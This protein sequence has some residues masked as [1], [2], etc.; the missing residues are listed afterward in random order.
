MRIDPECNTS[1]PL[2]LIRTNSGTNGVGE[3]HSRLTDLLTSVKI[4]LKSVY[5]KNLSNWPRADGNDKTKNGALWMSH[6]HFNAC[7]IL[8]LVKN[9]REAIFEMSRK[10]TLLF[11]LDIHCT[12]KHRTFL[13]FRNSYKY[14]FIK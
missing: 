2:P 11:E 6:N 14:L 10:I 12:H 8:I 13:F 4:T 1:R 5:Q 9:A 7:Y 3:A